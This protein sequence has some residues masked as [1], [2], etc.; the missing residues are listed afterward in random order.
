L[1]PSAA[2]HG[3]RPPLQVEARTGK[4]R[5]VEFQHAPPGLIC[6]AGERRGYPPAGLTLRR[7]PHALA[8]PKHAFAPSTTGAHDLKPR[9][10]G[11]NLNLRRVQSRQDDRRRHLRR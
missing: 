6:G 11:L 5:A 1:K 2:R 4:F 7:P 8:Y 9:R 3:Q 10:T